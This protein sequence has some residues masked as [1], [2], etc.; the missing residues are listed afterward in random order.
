MDVPR[1]SS[2]NYL[3][4]FYAGPLTPALRKVLGI[5]CALCMF[6]GTL[7]CARCDVVIPEE[8][9]EDCLHCKLNCRC[10]GG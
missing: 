5:T 8:C 4:K 9:E 10:K 2:T 7:D 3:S 1:K 6:W